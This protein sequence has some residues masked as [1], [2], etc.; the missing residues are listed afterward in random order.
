ML[1]YT[2]REV[3]CRDCISLDKLGRQRTFYHL[4]RMTEQKRIK[5]LSKYPFE[6]FKGKNLDIQ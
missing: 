2:T 5:I 4:Q 1:K 6:Q 3:T